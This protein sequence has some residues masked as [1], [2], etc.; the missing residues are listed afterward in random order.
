MLSKSGEPN[1]AIVRNSANAKA[2]S[3]FSTVITAMTMRLS[4][5]PQLQAAA[6][7]LQLRISMP[8]RRK[9]PIQN[10]TRRMP[11]FWEALIY[12]TRARLVKLR[13]T[14]SLRRNKRSSRREE[15]KLGKTNHAAMAEQ[16]NSLPNACY[17]RKSRRRSRRNV[18]SAEQSQ[19]EREKLKNAS[20]LVMAKRA[21]LDLNDYFCQK[22]Q[23]RR[24]R[25]LTRVRLS[26]LNAIISPKYL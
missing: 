7:F 24:W 4:S 1:A 2:T 22:L 5:T 18:E 20:R 21:S 16:A 19:K 13:R 3:R 14:Q 10:S 8:G 26:A 17:R 6:V 25:K 11:P 12:G 23:T 9:I 15:G